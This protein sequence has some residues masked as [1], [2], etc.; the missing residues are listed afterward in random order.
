MA[1]S[2]LFAAVMLILAAFSL[3]GCEEEVTVTETSEAVCAN[4]ITE[5]TVTCTWKKCDCKGFP[6]E[7]FSKLIGSFTCSNGTISSSISGDDGAD[8]SAG[9]SHGEKSACELCTEGKLA[10]GY[11][12]QKGNQCEI[13]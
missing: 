8:D 6:D 4:S 3:H 12:F 7:C 5:N 2:Q 1:A 13:L 10:S 9:T 11:G